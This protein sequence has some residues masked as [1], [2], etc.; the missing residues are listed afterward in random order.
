MRVVPVERVVLVCTVAA[1]TLT[2][3]SWLAVEA[4][5]RL[6]TGQSVFSAPAAYIGALGAV[7]VVGFA[8]CLFV[9]SLPPKPR[10]ID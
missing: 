2:L 9:A 1:A 8:A 3:A 10:L 5:A 7:L 6:V 4:V